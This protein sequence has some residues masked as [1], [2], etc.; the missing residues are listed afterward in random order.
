MATSH[1]YCSFVC[2]F[3]NESRKNNKKFYRLALLFN[4]PRYRNS[5]FLFSWFLS[6]FLFFLGFSFTGKKNI[7]CIVGRFIYT[8]LCYR[9]WDFSVIFTHYTLVKLTFVFSFWAVDENPLRFF[10]F[11]AVDFTLTSFP[12]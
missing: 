5:I 4:I 9:Y 2:L 1:T 10:T 7:Y 3:F 8:P 12:Y 11:L 6:V